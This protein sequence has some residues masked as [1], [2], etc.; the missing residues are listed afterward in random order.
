MELLLKPAAPP[1]AESGRSLPHHACRILIVD[2]DRLVY[3]TLAALIASEFPT[4]QHASDG[5]TALAMILENPPDVILLDLMMPGMTG[6]EVCRHIR[7]TP[8]ISQLPVIVLTALADRQTLVEALDAGADEFITKPVSGVELRA[9]IR[10]MLRIRRQYLELQELMAR[11]DRITHM[12]VHDF[13]SPLTVIGGA[14]DLLGM[15]QT[16]SPRTQRATSR[17]R[18]GAA[19]LNRLVDQVLLTAKSE[20][21]R[22]IAVPIESDLSALVLDIVG[23]FQAAAERRQISLTADIPPSVTATLDPDLMRRCIEN[24][25]TNALKFAPSGTTVVASLLAD[26]AELYISIADNGP[27]VPEESRAVIF[28]MFAAGGASDSANLPVGIGL[29]FCRLVARVHGGEVT[30]AENEPQGALFTVRLPLGFP[31]G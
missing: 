3:R 20:S 29:P 16:A 28:D 11:R 18:E 26:E 14:C 5:H 9:R 2:D 15:D 8:R 27:G 4:I 22:L 10:T 24:L 6:F 7:S 23:D 31:R 30:V 17:I 21:G 1:H 12:L 13:R 19:R 25:L